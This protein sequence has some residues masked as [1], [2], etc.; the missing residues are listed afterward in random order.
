MDPGRWRAAART[1]YWCA[2][3]PR[4][5]R[6]G[7]RAFGALATAQTTLGQHV[8]YAVLVAFRSPDFDGLGFGAA[9]HLPQ[10]C[11]P[12]ARVGPAASQAGAATVAPGGGGGNAAP[13]EPTP[14]R[15]FVT[16]VCF[17]VWFVVSSALERVLKRRSSGHLIFCAADEM[18][19]DHKPR[20]FYVDQQ[21]SAQVGPRGGGGRLCSSYQARGF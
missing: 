11:D 1:C 12:S 6:A 4:L 18:Q 20:W 9:L 14:R 7:I 3:R 21:S 19:Q 16:A 13:S 10:S 8:I 2:T 17:F 5:T 15:T